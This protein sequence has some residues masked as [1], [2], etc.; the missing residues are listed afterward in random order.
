MT[1]DISPKCSKCGRNVDFEDLQALPGGKGFACKLCAG[2]TD[3]PVMNEKRTGFI[4]APSA[5]ELR[6][7]ADDSAPEIDPIPH[8]DDNLFVE[9]E[10]VCDDCKYVFKRPPTYDVKTC[11]YCGKQGT[12]HE[13]TPE[14]AQDYIN[15]Q[16]AYQREE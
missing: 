8:T 1:L 15:E 3:S 14:Q 7:A 11:P 10:Y 12:V 9:K 16:T 4:E 2:E 5:N 13:N 6:S